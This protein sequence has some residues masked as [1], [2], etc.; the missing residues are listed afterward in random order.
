MGIIRCDAPVICVFY[1]SSRRTHERKVLV[2]GD[3]AASAPGEQ[4]CSHERGARVWA[5]FAICFSRTE[6]AHHDP[7]TAVAALSSQRAAHND[8]PYPPDN[9]RL[10]RAQFHRLLHGD[11]PA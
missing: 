10:G 4:I 8:L 5:A 7:G 9:H 2:R 11:L 6:H 3:G 1:T